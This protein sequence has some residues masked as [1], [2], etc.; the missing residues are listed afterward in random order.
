MPA[1][2]DITGQRFGRWTAIKRIE[3]AVSKNRQ[4][5]WLFHC[6]CG[7]Q[8]IAP[9]GDKTHGGSK[10]CGCLKVERS[11]ERRTTHG[12][13]GTPEFVCWRHAK[14]RCFNKNDK[15]YANYGGRGIT[16]CE[17]WRNSFENFYADMGPRPGPRYSIDRIDVNGNYEPGNCRWADD[18]VQARNKRMFRNN[19]SGINGVYHKKKP[20]RWH[21]Y[22]RA[23]GKQ[24][25][26]GSF[27]SAEEAEK[28][29]KEA[30]AKYWQI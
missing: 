19:T 2:R 8:S 13:A 29:R 28:V 4:I 27:K 23:N 16:M 25:F 26:L 24:L 7:T 11:R 18:F 20:N 6:D 5:M 17:R 12:M 14:D 3:S 15:S 9:A 1:F 22:I 10:S 21:A 30:E